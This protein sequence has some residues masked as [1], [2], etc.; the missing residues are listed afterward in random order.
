MVRDQQLSSVAFLAL[1][2]EKMP[3]EPDSE[4]LSAVLG[5][6]AAALD[7]YVPDPWREREAG[8]LFG[9]ALAALEKATQED[10]VITWARTTIGVAVRTEDVLA[11]GELLDG[12][13]VIPALTLDQDMRWSIAMKYVVHG[14]AG[15]DE[16][17]ALEAERDKTDRGQR[18]LVE[19]EVARPSAEAKAQ[20]WE[21]MNGAGYGSLYLTRAAMAGFH[22]WRQRDILAPYTDKFFAAI[23]GIFESQDGE[24]ATM[25]FRSLF[26][27]YRAEPALLQRA[28]SLL[29]ATDESKS[30]LRRTLREAIDDLKR[31]IACRDYA[32]AQESR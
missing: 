14:L 20:A 8:L 32:L 12:R 23:P 1:V 24:F 22:W 25:Y 6:G 26:P 18:A 21:K 11:L 28:D 7:R 19:A 4:L 16:R 30:L 5:H 3:L 15:A 2:R 29:A 10:Q 13:R 17:V 9:A 27:G 31:T